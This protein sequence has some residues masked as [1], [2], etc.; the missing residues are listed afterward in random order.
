MGGHDPTTEKGHAL[1]QMERIFQGFECDT[2]AWKI[3]RVRALRLFGSANWLDLLKCK[4][5]RDASSSAQEELYLE[6][7][8]EAQDLFAKAVRKLLSMLATPTQVADITVGLHSLAQIRCWHELDMV[9]EKQKELRKEVVAT[10][11]GVLKA[12]PD[13]GLVQAL[14]FNVLMA[15]DFDLELTFAVLNHD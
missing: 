6:A 12:Y 13:D 1:S 11:D 3:E 10:I 7:L 4:Y 2:G 9:T 5:P 14:T 15:P 8:H